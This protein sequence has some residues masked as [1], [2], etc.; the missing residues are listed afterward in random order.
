MTKILLTLREFMM[1]RII[2]SEDFSK[3]ERDVVRACDRT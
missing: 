1:K 2:L 3:V